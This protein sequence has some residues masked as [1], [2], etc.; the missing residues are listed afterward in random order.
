MNMKNGI[1]G[2]LFLTVVV[3]LSGCIRNSTVK[4]VTIPEKAVFEYDSK[5]Y[6]T[7][8]E[9]SIISKEEFDIT[10]GKEGYNKSQININ[11]K[12]VEPVINIELEPIIKSID[13][14]GNPSDAIVFY[15]DSYHLTG[16]LDLGPEDLVSISISKTGYCTQDFI[17]PRENLSSSLRYKLYSE[18]EKDFIDSI[19]LSINQDSPSLLNETLKPI[20]QFFYPDFVEQYDYFIYDSSDAWSLNIFFSSYVEQLIRNDDWDKVLYIVEN[21][22]FRFIQMPRSIKSLYEYAIK[23]GQIEI[24]K[25]LVELGI[26]FEISRDF[27]GGKTPELFV[28]IENNSVEALRLLLAA[29]ANPNARKYIPAKIEGYFLKTYPVIEAFNNEEMRNVLIAYGADISVKKIE[30]EYETSKTNT[31][32]TTIVEQNGELALKSIQEIT[33]Q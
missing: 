27:T 7:P 32:K 9:I 33:G 21:S 18:S 22:K 10:I 1:N 12:K 31:I 14:Y 13:I 20:E 19:E 2:V 26:P 30:T 16:E 6:T 25:R 28:C 24:L 23:D 15:N 5:E 4:I 8:A 11:P 17:I 29:G 3:L